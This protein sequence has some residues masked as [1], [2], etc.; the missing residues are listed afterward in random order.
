MKPVTEYREQYKTLAGTFE[1]EIWKKKAMEAIIADGELK[2]YER[3]KEHCSHYAWIQK[4]SELEECA[5]DSMCHRSYRAWKDFK[6][7]ET[8]I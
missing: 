4:E 7:E 1:P 8:I 6:Y 2:L 3:V 5:I